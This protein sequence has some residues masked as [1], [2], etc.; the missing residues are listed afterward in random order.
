VTD[1]TD[2]ITSEH[3]KPK[4]T[5][6]IEALTQGQVDNQALLSALYSYFDLDTAVG[7]QLDSVGRWIGVSRAL[8]TPLPNVYFSLDT[9]GLGFNQGT[10]WYPGAP[11]FQLATLPDDAYRILLKAKIAANNWDG[12]EPTAVKI[13][14]DL[15]ATQYGLLVTVKDNQN[16]SQSVT[17]S[18]PPPDAVVSGLISSGALDLKPATVTSLN[19]LI[20]PAGFTFVLVPVHATAGIGRAPVSSGASRQLALV[21]VHSAAAIRA[22]TAQITNPSGGPVAVAGKGWY[23]DVLWNFGTANAGTG[24]IKSISDVTANGGASMR[25]LTFEPGDLQVYNADETIS[26]QNIQFFV[27]HCDLLAIWN[28]GP[29]GQG[30]A[31][32]IKSFGIQLVAPYSGAVGYYELECKL[33]KVVGAHAQFRAWGHTYGAAIGAFNDEMVRILNAKDTSTASILSELTATATASASAYWNPADAAAVY[34]F[35][36]NNLTFTRGGTDWTYPDGLRATPSHATGKYYW[37]IHVDALGVTNTGWQYLGAANAAWDFS[38]TD[39]LGRDGNSWAF[40]DNI[41]FFPGATGWGTPWA[42]GDIIQIAYDIDNQKVWIGQNGTWVSGAPISTAGTPVGPITGAMMP[43][44]Q[45]SQHGITLTANFGATPFTYSI[46]SGFS[47]WGGAGG[48]TSFAYSS[49]GGNPAGT[50][51]VTGDVI[52]SAAGNMGSSTFTPSPAVDYSTA[53]HRIGM[54]IDTNFNISFWVDD[55]RVASFASDQFKNSSGANDSLEVL[56]TLGVVG[57][58][59]TF[60]DLSSGTDI[61]LTNNQLTLSPTQTFFGGQARSTSAH[62]TGKWMVEFSN[63]LWQDA[64]GT[65]TIL[66][67]GNSSWSST[68][69]D[70]LGNEANSFGFRMD[71]SVF[72]AGVQTPGGFAGFGTPVSPIATFDLCIDLDNRM[73]WGR[74]NGGNWNNDPAADPATNIGGFSIAAVTGDIY[75]AA[76]SV[77]AGDTI[78]ANFGATGFTYAIPAGFAA[79]DTSTTSID[80][81]SFGGANNTADTNK[82]RFGLKTLQIWSPNPVQP[83]PPPPPPPTGRIPQ[84]MLDVTGWTKRRDWNFGTAA[85]NNITSLTD[86]YNAGWH[87]HAGINAGGPGVPGVSNGWG[88]ETYPDDMSA[89]FVMGSDHVDMYALYQGGTI[90]QWSGTGAIYTFAAQY[91]VDEAGIM[92]APCYMEAYINVNCVTGFWPAWWC[93]GHQAGQPWWETDWGPE[94]DFLEIMPASG[95]TPTSWPSSLH[96][97]NNGSN[98]C[99]GNQRDSA[100]N[101]TSNIPLATS[102]FSGCV[103]TPGGSFN[104]GNFTTTGLLDF[105][106]GYHTFGCLI[107]TNFNISFYFDD[108]KVGTALAT[109]FAGDAGIPCVPYLTIDLAAGAWAGACNPADFGGINNATPTNKYRMS[110]KNIQIW[111]P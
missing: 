32:G 92:T 2:F 20:A 33:P 12:T 29:I 96:A 4:F 65:W 51:G 52:G 14:N 50:V 38:T 13:W 66:G 101:P 36:N 3:R 7:M 11:Q 42:V 24:A 89:S 110:F 95:T 91:P 76:S 83:P 35:A 72:V 27:D 21:G 45:G 17:F 78:T 31:S 9:P 37:E 67:G 69:T 47:A 5:A 99:F 39:T 16:M 49:A 53:F 79:W 108:V 75:A 85:G 84:A 82:Y 87:P 8:Q 64:S 34:T 19:S 98:L 77:N 88:S 106:V 55:A 102:Y 10:W 62:S 43:A 59:A 44:F 73:I 80:T 100:G 104:V 26:N 93:I 61:A 81:A 1:Y 68:G 74:Q 107:D 63:V 105:T 6:I 15:F 30:G 41:F 90:D 40:Q 48:A 58:G 109:Q 22:I 86:F 25:G 54:L 28:G 56:M 46:P 60:F 97:S 111:S 23:Q 71:G 70:T 94:I 103:W 18:G 57:T